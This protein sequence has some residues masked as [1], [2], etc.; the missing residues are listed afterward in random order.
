MRVAAACMCAVLAAGCGAAAAGRSA[1]GGRTAS[2]STTAPACR[3]SELAASGAPRGLADVVGL[4]DR[5]SAPCRLQGYLGVALPDVV[6]RPLTLDVVHDATVTRQG[7]ETGHAPTRPPGVTLTPGAAPTAWVGLRWK[8]LCGLAPDQL[9]ADLVLPGDQL[10]PVD[11]GS[12]W[13]TV[14]CVDA[15]APFVLEE[16]PVQA[17]APG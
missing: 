17:P 4:I 9:K 16:G 3:G 10:V 14:S 11:V 15:S 8:N 12:V 6:G 7:F 13:P 2:S 1:T 5:G